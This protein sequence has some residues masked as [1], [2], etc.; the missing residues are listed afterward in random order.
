MVRAPDHNVI[1]LV[2]SALHFLMITDS[3]AM[4]LSDDHVLEERIQYV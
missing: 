3:V 2:T 1:T 4:F